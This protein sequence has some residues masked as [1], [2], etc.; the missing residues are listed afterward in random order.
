MR[1]DPSTTRTGTNHGAIAPSW[2]R[3]ALACVAVAW[4]A[5]A[6]AWAQASTDA[7]FR[8]QANVS[9]AGRRFFAR[10]ANCVA[11]C[12]ARAQRGAVPVSDCHFPYGGETATCI[13]DLTTNATG[14]VDHRFR[15]EIRN[16][17]DSMVRPSAAC[18]ACY[19][20]GDCGV[21]GHAVDWVMNMAGFFDSFDGSVYCEPVPGASDAEIRCE[22]STARR[23]WE[24]VGR[25]GKCYDR[26]YARARRGTID[27]SSCTWLSHDPD[28]TLSACIAT[29]DT[30]T[31]VHIDRVC[32]GAAPDACGLTYPSGAE[33]TNV[34]DNGYVGYVVA[35]TYC[36]P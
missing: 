33:W 24:H 22:A 34:F 30:H 11:T 2:A 36:A 13:G 7:E 18:P 9:K 4:S 27:A 20:G 5:W 25:V 1:H 23:L 17:C 6:P 14:G 12:I 21:T 31:I 28:P 16:A 26:C 10:R 3:L 35:P 29:A 15:D 8:C 32:A 19:T